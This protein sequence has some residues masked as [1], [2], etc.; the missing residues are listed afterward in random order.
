MIR[1][2]VIVSSLLVAAPALAFDPPVSAQAAET[3]V[4][5]MASFLEWIADG[6]RG[7]YIRADT[8]RWYYARTRAPCPRLANDV[9]LRFETRGGRDLDR[10]GAIRAEGWRCDLASVTESDGPPR[11]D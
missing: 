7:L 6:D 4:P 11:R 9:A 2:A 5:R 8:G 10:F 3:R 1:Q